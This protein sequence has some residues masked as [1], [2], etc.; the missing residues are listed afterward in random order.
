MLVASL[1]VLE[2]AVLKGV[3]D[4]GQRNAPFPFSIGPGG[5]GRHLQGVKGDAGITI[6]RGQQKCPGVCFQLDPHLPQ[7]SLLI[8]NGPVHYSPYLFVDQ[9]SQGKDAASGEKGR[10]DLEG[11]VLCGSA[12][13][14]H[15]AILHIG[16]DNV[17]LGLVE[18][19]DLIYEQDGPLAM[20][21]K[22]IVGLA[23]DLPQVR[24]SSG[25]GAYLDEV[26]MGDSG[27][28]LGQGGLAAA[29]WAPKYHGGQLVGLDTLAQHSTLR[30]QVLLPY[31]LLE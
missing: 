4:G 11:W 28:E 25:N 30:H 8:G 20:H 15:R 18:A 13:E 12:D 23:N 17:L 22:A 14:D 21:A 31:K 26:G 10:Y 16:Q 19:M 2:S 29:W 1:V 9:A 7:P 3:L 27:D 6:G 5:R 24:H